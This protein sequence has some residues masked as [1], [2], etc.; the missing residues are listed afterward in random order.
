MKQRAPHSNLRPLAST[1]GA[2]LLFPELDG[3]LRAFEVHDPSW[4]A[5]V[6]RRLAAGDVVR[7]ERSG[8][9]LFT[10]P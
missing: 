4:V 1:E 7:I 10:D 6:L 3:Q 8:E 9:W 2:E 5:F